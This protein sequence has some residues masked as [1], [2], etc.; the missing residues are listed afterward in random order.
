M[1]TG[2]DAPKRILLMIG[3]IL[4][5]DAFY[6]HGNKTQVKIFLLPGLLHNRT[7]R[8]QRDNIFN[9]NT[10]ISI[11]LAKKKKKITHFCLT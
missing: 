6:N 2:A 8:V 1:K 5:H 11:R 4:L 9:N 3:D 10:I 7:R